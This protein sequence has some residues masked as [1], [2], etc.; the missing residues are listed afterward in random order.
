MNLK[1]ATI[2]Y[3]C[4][5]EAGFTQRDLQDKSGIHRNSIVRYENGSAPPV[6]VFELL[7][8]ICGYELKVVKKGRR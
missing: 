3:E 6:D 2:L 5:K 8:D 7:L 1:F 4:R